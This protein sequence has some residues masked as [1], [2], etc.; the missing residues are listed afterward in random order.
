M[1]ATK[2]SVQDIRIHYHK[3]FIDDLPQAPSKEILEYHTKSAESLCQLLLVAIEA[4]VVIVLPTLIVSH[5][6]SDIRFRS[7]THFKM[8]ILKH[9]VLKKD[10]RLFQTYLVDIKSSF[11]FWA[12][13]YVK[14]FCVLSNKENHITLAQSFVE[15]IFINVE[16]VVRD[17]DKSIPIK[18]WLQQFH[19][20]VNETLTIDL[21][22]IQYLIG[23]THA[24][25]NSK[26]F[27][28]TLCEQLTEG[29]EKIMKKM[30]DPYSKFSRITK[31]DN[32]P[33]LLLY[34]NII[35]CTEQ[36]PF[37]GEQCELTDPDHV[38]HGEPHFVN[39]HRPQYLG[40]HTSDK[41]VL[42]LCTYSVQSGKSFKNED[43]NDKWIPYED[44]RSI[45][46][47]WYISADSPTE[48]P[49]YW[50]WFIFNFLDEIIEW[51]GTKPTSIDDLELEIVTQHEAVD[52]IQHT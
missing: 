38:A 47:N 19:Q 16:A 51:V 34:E 29:K 31:W 37:C 35:G 2:G 12:E 40:R 14:E 13:Q 7:K 22:E 1:L 33:H 8:M 18:S 42:D 6:R 24:G 21:G 3:S 23:A 36:C 5:F 44:Y 11:K 10:F 4:E 45:Y 9:L 17:V 30:A 52:S 15:R 26:Y 39:I 25:N 41:L 32:P 20:K 48:S 49:K 46:K 28:N 50:Q 43:T 27:V